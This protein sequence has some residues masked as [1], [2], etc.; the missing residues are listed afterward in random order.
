MISLNRLGRK[1][2]Q[3]RKI[4]NNPYCP[5]LYAESRRLSDYV[6]DALTEA[7]GAKKRN[8]WETDT[9]SGINWATMPVTI[10]ELGFMTNE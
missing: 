2:Q 7:T 9:M 8:V 5:E 6:L 3:V 10:V 4:R 1:N